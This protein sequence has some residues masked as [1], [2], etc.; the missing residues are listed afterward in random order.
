MCGVHIE[1][2]DDSLMQKIRCLDE[3]VDELASGQV[4]REGRAGVAPRAHARG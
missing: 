3:L 4:D 2:I 1:D